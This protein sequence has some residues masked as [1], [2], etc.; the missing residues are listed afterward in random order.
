MQQTQELLQELRANEA[1]NHLVD[2]IQDPA[3]GRAA[4]LEVNKRRRQEIE[5]YVQFR[6][7]Y[8]PMQH[9]LPAVASSVPITATTD[10]GL[11]YDTIV[12]GAITNG[13]NRN[14]K[15][16]Y[17]TDLEYRLFKFG[18]TPNLKQTLD[19]IAGHDVNTAGF[20]GVLNWPYPMGLPENVPLY[21]EMYQESSPGAE[22]S[23]WT[24]FNGLRVYP[25]NAAETFLSGTAGSLVDRMIEQTPTPGVRWAVAKVEFN[26]QGQ[27]TAYSP[28]YINEVYSVLGFR[29]TNAALGS[30]G[31]VNVAFDGDFNASFGTQPFPMFAMAAEPGNT[32]KV[33]EPLPVPLFIPPKR[34]LVFNIANAI[35]DSGNVAQDGNIEMLIVTP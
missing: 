25:T 1:L 27:A 2:L 19:S 17:N 4:Q 33:F 23:V 12:T 6:P 31:L 30:Y 18:N 20:P 24:V 28:R 10:E 11:Q 32:Q 22:Q 13:E 3:K 26:A 35:D 7:Q 21:M 14:V 29:V 16:Y 9:I 15:L 34:Q 5:R 8:L